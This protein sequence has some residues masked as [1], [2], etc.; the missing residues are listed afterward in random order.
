MFS[1]PAFQQLQ[2]F[3]SFSVTVQTSNPCT[4]ADFV[5]T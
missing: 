3:I 2:M 1:D 5:V 4:G